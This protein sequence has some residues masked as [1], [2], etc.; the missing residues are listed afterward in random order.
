MW[1]EAVKANLPSL[2]DSDV[3]HIHPGALVGNFLIPRFRRR[4]DYDL[5]KL[6]SHYETGGKGPITVSGGQGDPGGVSYGSYQMTSKTR[7]PN[8]TFVIGGTVLKFISTS[9]FPWKDDFIGLTPGTTAFSQ[10]WKSIVTQNT[11]EFSRIEHEYIRRTHFDV[12]VTKILQNT[13]VDIRYHSHAINDVTWSTSVHHGPTTDVIIKSIQS[14]NI[15]PSET[16]EYD[17]LL[18]EAIYK[19]R[20]KKNPEGKLIRFINST[21]AIQNGISQRFLSESEKALKELDNEKDY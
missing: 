15:T 6:S 20:G 1:W 5:G 8:G 10:K 7:L 21:T 18:I 3:F 19:E 9:D 13:Q 4:R 12:L 2:P 16:K 11:E 17:R 14:L